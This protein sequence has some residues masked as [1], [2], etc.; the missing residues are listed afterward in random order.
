[1]TFR[2]DV[3]VKPTIDDTEIMEEIIF[4]G[5]T[6]NNTFSLVKCHLTHIHSKNIEIQG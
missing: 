4:F 1:M 3:H 5:V 2:K 6:L